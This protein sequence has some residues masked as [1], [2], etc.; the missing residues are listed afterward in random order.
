MVRVLAKIDIA[1]S[2]EPS[3]EASIIGTPFSLC[4]K[5]FSKTTMELSTNIPI[6][7]A[8]PPKDMMFSVKPK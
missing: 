5:I 2:P 3:I 7:R 8:T 1:T 4:L 6:P